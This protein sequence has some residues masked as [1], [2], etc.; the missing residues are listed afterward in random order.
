MSATDP[1]KSSPTSDQVLI[2]RQVNKTFFSTSGDKVEA[3]RAVD[4]SVGRGEF[5]VLIGPTGCGKT[6]LL[7]ILGGLDSPDG[8]EI[9]FAPGFRRED[10]LAYVF[11]HYTLF[12]WRKLLANVA[13]GLQMRGVPRRR[14]NARA[15][16]LLQRVG[17]ADFERAYPHELSGG[18]RQRVALAQ[19]LA[20][21]PSV[22]LM[23][24]P[25]GALDDATRKDLQQLL[26]D[27]WQTTSMS[28]LFV[29]HNID[30]A[31][32]LASRICVL[33]GRPGRVVQD[34]PVSLPRPRDHLA[35]PFTDRLL[36]VRQ[37]LYSDT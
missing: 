6:T 17:L 13:F 14:R 36:I 31:V 8:G 22:L 4:L 28:V 26:I 10:G 37:A 16:D 19:A 21:E 33:S 30:E 9:R 27:L 2:A 7:N 18:M 29:T 25:F 23:D 15:R 32:I 35:Q 5:V 24:E 1:N 20:V 34:I 12:P 11:Q 3:L